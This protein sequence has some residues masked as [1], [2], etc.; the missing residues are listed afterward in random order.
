MNHDKKSNDTKRANVDHQITTEVAASKSPPKLDG[1]RLLARETQL[2]HSV[3]SSIEHA[4]VNKKTDVLSLLTVLFILFRESVA[5]LQHAFTVWSAAASSTQVWAP[6]TMTAASVAYEFA[7]MFRKLVAGRFNEL[8][9]EHELVRHRFGTGFDARPDNPASVKAL[10][11]LQLYSLSDPA[12]SARLSAAGLLVDALRADLTDLLAKLESFM[13]IGPGP[14]RGK[15]REVRDAAQIRVEVIL[16]RLS[17]AMLSSGG[18]D[19]VAEFEALW[20]RNNSGKRANDPA[21]DDPAPVDPVVSVDPA[22]VVPVVPVVDD[23]EP[24]PV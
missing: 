20:P 2:K 23:V 4:S 11:A 13:S 12:L 19:M 18:P 22:P 21:P 16:S 10:L 14:Q 17:S 3:Q 5:A 6:G 9:D 1:E 7:A 24:A 15:A 8:T